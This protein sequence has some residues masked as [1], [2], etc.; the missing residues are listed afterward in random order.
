MAPR[1][2]FPY[3]DATSSPA[4]WFAITPDDDTDLTQSVRAIWVGTGGD[5]VLMGAD[6]NSETF[7]N[8]QSGYLFVASPARVLATATTAED[9]V[10]LP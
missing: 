5:L 9:L 10:G 6:G 4:D 7:K 1:T 3:R 2:Q 8:V